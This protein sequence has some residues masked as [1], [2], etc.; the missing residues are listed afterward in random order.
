M[1]YKFLL[2]LFLWWPC[3]LYCQ[4]PVVVSTEVITSVALPKFPD[5]TDYDQPPFY[6]KWWEEISQ[7]S[8]LPISVEDRHKVHFKAISGD[9]FTIGSE[10]AAFWG[11]TQYWSNTIYVVLP[12]LSWEPLIKH[13]MLHYLMWVNGLPVN[14]NPEIYSRCFESQFK[15]K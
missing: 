8:N 7:C 2:I 12:K 11:F 9:Q 6:D 13:E 4:K 15:L 14:H 1:L 10:K 3:K 5:V